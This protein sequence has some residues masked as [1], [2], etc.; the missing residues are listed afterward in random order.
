MVEVKYIGL[1]GNTIFEY[2]FGRILAEELG[3]KLKADPIPGF[4]NTKAKVEGHDY[5]GYP[6][7][8]LLWH[9]VDLESILQD[10]TKRKIT[11]Y[12]Y[13]QRYEYFKKYKD[14]IRNN[15]LVPTSS[16][17]I[18]ERPNP[19]DI[20]VYVRRG[21]DYMG[22]GREL[23]FSYYEDALNMAEYDRVFIGTDRPK[24]PFFSLFKKYKPTIHHTK[25]EP[26]K[27]FK[28]IMSFNKIIQSASTFSWWASFLSK[29][30]EIYTPI[31]L[32]GDWSDEY[33]ELDLTVDDEDR[34]I[35]VK[36]REVYQKTFI[37]KLPN[38][39]TKTAGLGTSEERF[40]N[41]MKKQREKLNK[42]DAE[43]IYRA[44]KERRSRK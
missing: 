43:R 34:Y 37:E 8:I 16:I 32:S 3:Y 12:G 30:K 33:P 2:C 14:V 28:F 38:V 41:Y 15:W 31:P 29:A 35:Y 7:Q 4:P 39:I 11:V 20:L 1:W 24:D 27:D 9:W 22:T 23:P 13:F 10:K 26:F 6:E 21:A 25:N 42:E 5:S 18:G 36:C 40:V 17:D 44:L 19:N